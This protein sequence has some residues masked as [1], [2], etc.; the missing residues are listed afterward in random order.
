MRRILLMQAVPRLQVMQRQ[1]SLMAES[2]VGKLLI[3]T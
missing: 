3:K 2:I 1:Q